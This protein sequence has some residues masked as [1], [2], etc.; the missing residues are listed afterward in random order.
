MSGAPL[1]LFAFL[2]GGSHPRATIE[3]HDIQFVVA[4]S[5]EET[6]PLLQQ[7]WWGNADSLHI[8]AFAQIEAVDGYRVTPVPADEAGA[9]DLSLYFVNTGGYQLGVFQEFHAYSFH[10]GTD[11]RAVWSAAKARAGGMGLLHQDN[12]DPIDDV[13]CIDDALAT[14]RYGLRFEP[15]PGTADRIAI[16]V[17]Y[18]PLRQM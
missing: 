1:R 18:V 11:K 6:F 7:R 15:A 13:V 4:R 8:D 12:L 16:K 9:G 17:G 5:V 14:Q 10:I 2:V 3:L